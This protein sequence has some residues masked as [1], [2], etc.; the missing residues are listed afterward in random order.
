MAT[1][2]PS[3]AGGARRRAGRARLRGRLRRAGRRADARAI[4][5]ETHKHAPRATGSRDRHRKERPGHPPG[6][7]GSLPAWP[8][9]PFSFLPNSRPMEDLMPFFL[10][11]LC[12]ESW[13]LLLLLGLLT[14]PSWEPVELRTGKGL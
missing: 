9:R 13:L 2:G 5:A 12:S 4:G 3:P 11:A 14:G 1:C 10:G 7:V 8:G 6:P